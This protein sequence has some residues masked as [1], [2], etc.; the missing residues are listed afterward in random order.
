MKARGS[1]KNVPGPSL[2][3]ASPD[4]HSAATLAP[5]LSIIA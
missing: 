4:Q 5:G 3:Q 1:A 2:I